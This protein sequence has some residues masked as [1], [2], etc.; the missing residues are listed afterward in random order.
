MHSVSFDKYAKRDPHD[1]PR[2]VILSP[3]QELLKIEEDRKR[4]ELEAAFIELH[5]NRD[6]VTSFKRLGHVQGIQNSVRM[7]K[8]VA[9]EPRREDYQGLPRHM[10]SHAHRLGITGIGEKDLAESNKLDQD[11]IEKETYFNRLN[12]S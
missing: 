4:V 2:K 8:G 7:A 5:M 11:F 1:R 6:I 12:N 3:Q 10:V 9:S